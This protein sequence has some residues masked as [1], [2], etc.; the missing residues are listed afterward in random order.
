MVNE[1]YNRLNNIA[2]KYYKNLSEL[3][4]K[5][6]KS[7]EFLYSY[8]NKPGIGRR[9]LMEM[10]EILNINP[11]YIKFGREPMLLTE[12]GGRGTKDGGLGYGEPNVT[13]IR[14]FSIREQDMEYLAEKLSQ[15]KVYNL[16][17]HA[18]T[19]NSLV[20]FEDLPTS[21]SQYILG[22]KFDPKIHKGVRISGFSMTDVGINDG[23]LV[24]YDVSVQPK[25][26]NIIICILNGV[27]LIKKYSHDK[28]GTI[29]L[30]SAHNGVEPIYVNHIDDKFE[31]I[32]VV[33]HT[34]N[35][36]Y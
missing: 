22:K 34:I 5:L 6:G 25:D 7:K 21:Y 28:D 35:D 14:E 19:S 3:S 15:I 23:A 36:Y 32:G 17:V 10:K 1:E 16:T 12:S 4:I 27:A 13:N 33:K 20:S 29:V 18:N 24:I 2:V 26:G 8:K 30:E 9:I 11:E 31:I